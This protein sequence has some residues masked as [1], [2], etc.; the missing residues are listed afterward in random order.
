MNRIIIP[1]P[2]KIYILILS[3]MGS[4]GCN[5][6]TTQDQAS[7]LAVGKEALPTEV[8][9]VEAR[10]MPFEY[11]VNTHGKIEALSEWHVQL[12]VPGVISN[13]FVKNGDYVNRGDLLAVIDSNKYKL[14]V[15][16]AGVLLR[17][18][19]IAFQDQIA[20][21]RGQDEARLK[22]IHDNIRYSSGLA[23][24]EVSY[25]QARLYY[26]NTSIR[27]GT[28][29]IISDLRVKAGNPVNTGDI[30]CLIHDPYRLGASCEIL[31]A[32]AH[33]VLK[34]QLANVQPIFEPGKTFVGSVNFINPR[35]DLKTGLVKVQLGIE[36]KRDLLPGMNVNITIKVPK[37]SANIVVPKEAIVVRSGAYVVFTC[38]DGLAKWNF[39]KIGKENGKEV[40]VIEGL[41]ENQKVI[42][43]NNLQLAHDAV[44]K[45]MPG[46]QATIR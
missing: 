13:V 22:V 9:T 25:E 26:E 6:R 8:V 28:S 34:G 43:T 35:V 11:L 21:F 37:G 18:R 2:N 45:E 12:L 29:G 46:A 16:K 3:L 5:D 44:V 15:D 40:E 10:R 31:E 41:S 14:E 32:D 19:Q 36:G 1:A 33:V 42:I 24:A 20:G 39:V 27:A 4:I 30:L 38:D 17:E 23:S 7:Q